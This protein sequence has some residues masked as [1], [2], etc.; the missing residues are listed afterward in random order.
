MRLALIGDI[1]HYRLD[2]HWRKLVGKRF[3]GQSNLWLNRRHRFNHGVL[4]PLIDRV[5]AI[6]PDHVLL[7][8]D[9]TTTS[10]DDEFHDVAAFLKP[11]S[12]KFPTLLVPG[13]HDRYTFSSNRNRRIERLL[14][15]LLPPRFP[16]FAN[17]GGRWHV[18][19]LDGARP[20]VFMARGEL[21]RN[22]IAAARQQIGALREEDGLIVMCHYP[23]GS[24]PDAL[25]LTYDHRLADARPLAKLLQSCAARVVYVH[26]HIHRPWVWSPTNGKHRGLTHIN[27]GAPCMT[28]A[29]YP[30]GQGFWQI[31]LPDDPRGELGLVHHLP[32]TNGRVARRDRKALALPGPEDWEMKLVL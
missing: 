12:D 4:S 20:R 6:K 32:R 15:H 14:E 3:L 17:V 27:A 19:A 29:V 13:N 5:E 25:P 23:I 31:D 30:L 22:Q 26:G 18:L 7:T 16:H 11:L 8:G 24:P 21:G 10:L 1:H 28:S 9:V 2:V